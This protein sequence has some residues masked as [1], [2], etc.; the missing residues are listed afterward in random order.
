MIRKHI[1]LLIALITCATVSFS[2]N[3]TQAQVRQRIN[4]ATSQISSMRCDFVQTKHMK[5]LKSK[6]TSRGKMYYSSPNKLRWEYTTPYQYTFMLNGQTVWM[7]NAKGSN[8]VNVTQSKMFKEITRIMMSSVL[9]TCVS[10][11]RDF[12][13]TLQGNGNEWKATMTPKKN[14]MKQMFK[15][16]IVTFNMR[17]GIVSGVRMVEKNGDTTDIVLKNVKTNVP[18]DAKLFSQH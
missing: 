12:S 16:V 6:V 13:V 9:G 15:S 14:P 5:M 1:L 11:S 4:Q 8:K 7:K 3:Y 17:E 2:Q 18:I 10:N